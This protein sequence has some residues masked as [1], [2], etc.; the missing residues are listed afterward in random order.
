MRVIYLAYG[1]AEYRRQGLFSALS[2]RH[3]D[4]T[5]RGAVTIY[6]DDPAPFE[7][8]GFA[9]VPVDRAM[10]AAGRGR[11]DFVH[12]LKLHVLRDA[13]GRLPD[14]EGWLLVDA[15][16]QWRAAPDALAD[17]LRA[18]RAVMHQSE[19]RVG[20]RSHAPVD[21]AVRRLLPGRGGFEMFN[22]GIIGLPAA[23]AAE[24]VAAALELTDRLLLHCLTR[25]WLE[26]AAVSLVLADRYPME[27]AGERVLHYWALNREVGV[28]LGPFFARHASEPIEA[29]AAAVAAFD[30][31][32]AAQPLR[33][34][35]FRNRG[36]LAA[37][38]DKLRRSWQKRRTDL[39]VLL[40]RLSLLFGRAS[41]SPP[42]AGASP[43]P[44][45]RPPA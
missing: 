15:D 36:S 33:D 21:R 45:P 14:A 4:R 18:G 20:P 8:A 22:S 37:R 12:R 17:A 7:Q 42:A 39:R 38:R 6:T 27:L 26:Q 24:A 41:P 35:T 32:A 13:I 9:T 43:A 16:T 3:H 34:G 10:V 29:L 28:V 25:T 2:L 44:A 11:F 31:V 40:A 19:G 1:A 5:G 30:P 23:G